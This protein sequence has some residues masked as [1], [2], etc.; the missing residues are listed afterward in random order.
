[1]LES[2]DSQ[3]MPDLQGH[4]ERKGLLGRVV[5]SGPWAQLGLRVRL[6]RMACRV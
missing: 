3:G 4:Q 2:L 6:D 1:M 5:T